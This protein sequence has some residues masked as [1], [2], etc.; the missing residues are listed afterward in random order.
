V[1]EYFYAITGHA[2]AAVELLA[3]RKRLYDQKR[4]DNL[5][6]PPPPPPPTATATAIAT[7]TPDTT[8]EWWLLSRSGLHVNSLIFAAKQIATAINTN[9]QQHFYKRQLR[10]IKLRDNLHTQ[11]DA[12]RRQEE[13]NLSAHC[14]HTTDD[15][16]PYKLMHSVEQDLQQYPEHFLYPMWVMNKHF[17]TADPPQKLFALLPLVR[18]F[19][20][21]AHLH[22]DTVAL[23]SLVGLKHPKLKA[24]DNEATVTPTP[25]TKKGK[26]KKRTQR[27][28]TSD[29]AMDQKDLA[30]KAFFNIEKAVS[31]PNCTQTLCSLHYD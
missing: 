3:A 13:I 11:D 8:N 25:T 18:G 2:K 16:L 23:C 28:D 6:P 22:I 17:E 1:L 14:G 26:K 21:G 19:V 27:R 7:P 20:P 9:I 31:T 10:Y 15:S 4:K 24:I 5:P 12:K 29:P 30:W